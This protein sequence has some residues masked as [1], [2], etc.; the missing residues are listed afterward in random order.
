MLSG[1]VTF[2]IGVVL[3]AVTLFLLKE[4]GRLLSQ[5]VVN[6]AMKISIREWNRHDLFTI[7]CRW[8]DY[9][10]K[11]ARSDMRLRPDCESAIAQ[12]L[13]RRYED[14]SSFGYIADQEA[15]LVGFLLGRIDEWESIP[16]V[17]ESR[18]IGIID[19]VYVVEQY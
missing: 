10:R 17:V 15:S 14:P 19:A 1:N 8:L 9:C 12:W 7:G 2:V 5:F 11:A 3:T 18:R 6:F 4:R 16:P 13:A